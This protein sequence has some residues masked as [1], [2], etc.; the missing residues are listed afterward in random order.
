[1]TSNFNSQFFIGLLIGVCSPLLFLPIILFVMSIYDGYSFLNLW[2]KFMANNM[3]SSKFLSLAL[4]GNLFWFYLFL[5]K[6][7]ILSYERDYNGNV[8][9]CS[10]YGLYLFYSVMKKIIYHSRRAIWRF[11]RF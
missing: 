3:D 11:T 5:N 9:L 7:E 4:I 1:M 10:L 8:M 6:R 2:N